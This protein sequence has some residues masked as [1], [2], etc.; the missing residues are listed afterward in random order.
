[1]K[2]SALLFIP[3]FLSACGGTTTDNNTEASTTS[4]TMEDGPGSHV[5]SD[6]ETEPELTPESETDSNSLPQTEPESEPEIEF[7]SQGDTELEVDA[8]SPENLEALRRLGLKK[9]NY[10][11]QPFMKI[12]Q[13][14]T[15]GLQITTGIENESDFGIPQSSLVNDLS[16]VDNLGEPI[17]PQLLSTG[18]VFR[19]EFGSENI[20]VQC[21]N[22]VFGVMNA[23]IPRIGSPDTGIA[24]DYITPPWL[25]DSGGH[26]N[27][28]ADA[29]IWVSIQSDVVFRVYKLL[30]DEH[31]AQFGEVTDED[32]P[33]IHARAK[34]LVSTLRGFQ[35]QSLVNDEYVLTPGRFGDPFRQ[36]L[37]LANNEFAPIMEQ[38]RF[39]ATNTFGISD[40]QTV[41]G[42][43]AEYLVRG[44]WPDA[45]RNK[46]R[47]GYEANPGALISLDS[48]FD[49][50]DSS[51]TEYRNTP[52]AYGNS[53]RV[54][55]PGQ[56][57]ENRLMLRLN[58]SVTEGQ[59]SLQH[60]FYQQIDMSNQPLQAVYLVARYEELTGRLEEPGRFT[61]PEN[62]GMAAVAIEYLDGSETPIG[63]TLFV[64]AQDG[65]LSDTFLQSPSSLQSSGSQ[66]VHRIPGAG[67]AGLVASLEVE[68]MAALRDNIQRLHYARIY[69]LV[70]DYLAEQTIVHPIWGIPGPPPDCNNC[71]AQLTANSLE[72]RMLD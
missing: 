13:E 9:I 67:N 33:V 27:T 69:V 8:N 14:N 50:I 19:R 12:Y 11:C 28:S 6:L 17:S 29:A 32:V 71:E 65:L 30:A 41:F 3:L 22:S 39:I 43:L 64:N 4:Q 56:N 62:S 20:L 38:A 60:G 35:P 51:W 24:G 61:R 31:Q 1:M 16:Y 68:A 47:A 66:I 63:S 23:F 42:V 37:R 25:G 49:N 21:V 59:E 5:D 54:V 2:R 10:R 45:F 53:E 26:N 18:N 34:E 57:G 44:S 48:E 15:I 46:F 7:E 70:G 40:V 55:V 36:A 72:L 52:A 58:S